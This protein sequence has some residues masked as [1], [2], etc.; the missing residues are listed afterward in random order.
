MTREEQIRASWEHARRSPTSLLNKWDWRARPIYRM[1][2]LQ[3]TKQ[4]LSREPIPEIIPVQQ[5][6]AEVRFFL[7]G[8]LDDVPWARFECEEI[9]LE[10]GLRSE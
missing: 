2:L 8:Y 5:M 10:E 3:H 7:Q 6:S 9:V 1:P 4:L